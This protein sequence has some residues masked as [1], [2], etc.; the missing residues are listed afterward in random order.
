MRRGW[1]YYDCSSWRREGLGD[2]INVYKYFVEGS[3]KMEADSSPRCPVA[4]H[5]ALC[6]YWKST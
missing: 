2:F 6:M 3:K 4:K 5:K 1:E